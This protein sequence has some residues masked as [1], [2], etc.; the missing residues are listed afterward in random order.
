[1]TG[2][3][4]A[5]RTL[6]AHRLRVEVKSVNGRGLDIRM[7]LAA[8]LDALEMPL[9]QALGRALHRGSV[10]LNLTLDRAAGG[11]GL[12]L[13]PLALEGVLDALETLAGRIAAE[14][15]RLEGILAIPGVLVAND[16][17]DADEAALAAAVLE[18]ADE[19]IGKLRT[20]RQAEGAA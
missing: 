8:G 2:F 5:E 3:A 10:T 19:A 4:R 12:R 7:R 14:P 1:M 13:D 20:A 15:P 11:S 9:R 18:A 6:G 17:A 16:G